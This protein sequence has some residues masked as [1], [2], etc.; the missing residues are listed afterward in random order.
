MPSSCLEQG[1]QFAVVNS[2]SLKSDG[3]KLSIVQLDE[4]APALGGVAAALAMRAIDSST[5]ARDVSVMRAD[6]ELQLHFIGDD[7]VLR[8]AV[9]GADG[10]HGRL[11]GIAFPAHDRLQIEND[12]GGKDDRIDGGVR[13]RAVAA[14]AFARGYRRNRRWPASG[15]RES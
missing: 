1:D 5:S 2:F 9:D 6:G 3:V 12:A 8:A 10:H 4:S 13:G 11:D 7:V 15:L 14:F